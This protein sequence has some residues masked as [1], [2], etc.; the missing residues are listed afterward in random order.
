MVK[1]FLF[2]RLSAMLIVALFLVSCASATASPTS[3]PVS[4][5]TPA[6]AQ[7]SSP[8]PIPEVTIGVVVVDVLNVREGPG[9]SYP[10]LESLNKDAKFPILGE[11][12]NNTN[13]KWLLISRADNS[14]GW[15][16]GDQSYVTV[17]KEIVDLDTYLTWQRN[18]ESGKSLLVISTPSP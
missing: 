4:L 2:F 18:V 8:T 13:N 17:Q 5:E 1:H 16:A 11:I 9:T 10:I 14:F 15:V 6:D 3:Q 12:T 7:A